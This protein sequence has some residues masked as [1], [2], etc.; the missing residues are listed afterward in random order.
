MRKREG[1]ES[2]N[3]SEIVGADI[4]GLMEGKME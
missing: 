2:R 1:N 3:P 4:I